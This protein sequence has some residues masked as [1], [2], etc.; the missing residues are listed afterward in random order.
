M[1]HSLAK[2]VLLS[3][4][5]AAMS[6]RRLFPTLLLLCVSLLSIQFPSVVSSPL[7]FDVQFTQYGFDPQMVLFHQASPKNLSVNPYTAH[8]GTQVLPRKKRKKFVP[9]RCD[10]SR[11][12]GVMYARPAPLRGKQAADEAA[13]FKMTLC[14]KL[15]REG[16][17]K[18]HGGSIGLF[19]FL[20]PYPWNAHD[21]RIEVGLDSNCTETLLDSI[22]GSSEAVVCAHVQYDSTKE[23]LLS[24]VR[25]GDDSCMCVR[26]LDRSGMPREAAV[27]FASTTAGDPIKWGNILTWAFHSTLESEKDHPLMTQPQ[28]APGSWIEGEQ[29]LRV[30]PWNRNAELSLVN[31]RYQQNWLQNFQLTCS[32]SVSVGYGN[33][34]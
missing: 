9:D 11:V 23:L 1:S 33:A 14:L 20:V 31:L 22:T 24:T 30:D 8:R 18:L 6:H 15:D 21:E 13:S 4:L 7:S 10:C 12:D 26:N 28:E 16:T 25:I 34:V 29:R 19:L 27:G 3:S 5:L 2:I 32:L 17:K